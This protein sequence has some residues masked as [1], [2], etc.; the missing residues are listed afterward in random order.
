MKL[1]I[2]TRQLSCQMRQPV[3]QDTMN[4]ALSAGSNFSLDPTRMPASQVKASAL[5]KCDVEPRS[6]REIIEAARCRDQRPGFR[7]VRGGS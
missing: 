5:F 3:R 6:E 2:E 1:F 4:A 7:T